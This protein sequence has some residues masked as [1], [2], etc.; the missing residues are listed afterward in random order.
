MNH[1]GG[2][3]KKQNGQRFK[4][5]LGRWFDE[6]SVCHRLSQANFNQSDQLQGSATTSRA[7]REEWK[8]FLFFF[9]TKS[10]Q[11]RSLH[12]QL[13]TLSSSDASSSYATLSRIHHCCCQTNDPFSHFSHLKHRHSCQKFLAGCWATSAFLLARHNGFMNSQDHMFLWIDK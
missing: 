8:H 9:N 10:L 6:P 5:I 1:L 2:R 13:K 11:W 12:C 3:C 7:W 4:K